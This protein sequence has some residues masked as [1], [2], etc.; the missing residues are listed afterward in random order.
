MIV[1]IE[2]DFKSSSLLVIPMYD[3]LLLVIVQKLRGYLL[4]TTGHVFHVCRFR[5]K[6]TVLQTYRR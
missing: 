2:S 1:E 4:Q 5:K 6:G 3:G